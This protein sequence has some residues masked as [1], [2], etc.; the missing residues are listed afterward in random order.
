MTASALSTRKPM[1][2]LVSDAMLV[3]S[4]VLTCRTSYPPRCH[5]ELGDRDPCYEHLGRCRRPGCGAPDRTERVEDGQ[6]GASSLAEPR[7][8]KYHTSVIEIVLR[9]R[10]HIHRKP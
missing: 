8:R 4:T 9:T 1:P 5:P 6:G 2:R 3:C 10:L 7:N